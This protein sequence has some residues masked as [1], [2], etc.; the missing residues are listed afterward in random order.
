MEETDPLKVTIKARE[1]VTGTALA[2]LL[3][4]A[5]I[6]CEYADEAYLVL[7]V[8]P[9]N[10]EEDLKRFVA[11]MQGLTDRYSGRTTASQEKP[12]QPVH[13]RQN[14]SIRMAIFSGQETVKVT[15]ALGR[16]CG[17]PTVSCP[18]AIP[19][20]VPGEVMNEKA[21][22]LFLY[23]GIERVSVLKEVSSWEEQ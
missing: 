11:A 20:A 19:I 13:C 16:T 23:Y 18:P 15:E 8:T 4:T 7:M 5:Q 2:E 6:E 21:I 9:E 22:R 14:C 17:E 12:L 3:R 10:G 1:G